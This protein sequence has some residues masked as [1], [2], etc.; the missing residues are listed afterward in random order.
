MQRGRRP[1]DRG[2]GRCNRL[3]RAGARQSALKKKQLAKQSRCFNETGLARTLD[4]Q[5]PDEDL[6]RRSVAG[7]G[8]WKTWTAEAVLR[9]G[10]GSETATCRQLANEVEGASGNQ[11]RAARFVCANAVCVSQEQGCQKIVAD[12]RSE[13]LRFFVRN[14]MFDEST[15]DLKIGRDPAT[16]CSV[17]CSHAQWTMGF[18]PNLGDSQHTVRDEHIVRSPEILAPMNSA[19]MWKALCD[20]PGGLGT[21]EMVADRVCTLTTCDAH[22]ANLK[23]LK[24]MDSVLH[25]DH[26]FLPMLCTQ[27]RNGNVVEQLTHLL[28]N[29][30]GCFCVSRVLNG[31]TNYQAL[32]KRVQ[33]WGTTQ[34]MDSPFWVDSYP[35]YG[36]AIFL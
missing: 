23:V 5:L 17:L 30:G 29:L 12:S 2:L 8:K 34:F 19:T 18:A 4:H 20:H 27:H 28:G 36:K 26:L 35:F 3:R 24:H 9:T 6:G 15:F 25:A 16:S 21:T 31:S 7:K 14:L 11:A 10:F 33:K 32:Q 22:S 13:P 1:L